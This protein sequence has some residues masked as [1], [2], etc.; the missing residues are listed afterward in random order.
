MPF[1]KNLIKKISHMNDPIQYFIEN[2][3]MNKGNEE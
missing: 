2:Y 1:K 3:Y